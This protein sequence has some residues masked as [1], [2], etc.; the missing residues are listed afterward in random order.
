MEK[1]SKCF[2]NNPSCQGD[3]SQHKLANFIGGS[4]DVGRLKSPFISHTIKPLTKSR[5]LQTK[6]KERN[7]T[8]LFF[9][10]QTEQTP[11]RNSPLSRIR[12]S[13]DF[14]MASRFSQTWQGFLYFSFASGVT[15]TFLLLA[16]FPV[17]LYY[18]SRGFLYF[19]IA[20]RVSCT[21]L[22]LAEFPVVFYFRQ[23]FLYFSIAG[24]F[25]VLVYW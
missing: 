6:S 18:S 2:P 12:Q 14:K 9:R 5:E 25:P 7:V 24:W 21:L 10:Q 16:G 20:G 17:V 1:I 22:L 23:G 3:L 19:S 4:V 11:S 15:C 8:Q 13:S